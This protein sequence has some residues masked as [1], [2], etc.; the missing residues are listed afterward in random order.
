MMWW[1]FGGEFA[2]LMRNN[3]CAGASGEEIGRP[4]SDAHRSFDQPRL[5]SDHEFW[6]GERSAF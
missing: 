1:R 3:L 4:S 2:I 5:A 6:H